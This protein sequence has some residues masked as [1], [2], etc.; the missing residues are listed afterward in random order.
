MMDAVMQEKDRFILEQFQGPL[1]LL[2]HLVQRCEIDLA[3]I[4]IQKITEQCL[5]KLNEWEEPFIDLGAEFVGTTAFLL[6]LKSRLL[7][8]HDVDEEPLPLTD[9]KDLQ[10]MTALVDYCR[11]KK[12]ASEL[13]RREV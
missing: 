11:C 12:V 8:P 10:L 13:A 3:D 4:P 5:M 6:Y 9:L 7:V 1:E 2:L